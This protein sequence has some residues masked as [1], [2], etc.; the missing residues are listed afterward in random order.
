MLEIDDG[1]EEAFE[2]YIYEIF[3]DLRLIIS[4][5]KQTLQCC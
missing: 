2:K 5:I 3:K 1:C 4:M